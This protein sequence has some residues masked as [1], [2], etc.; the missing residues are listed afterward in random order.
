MSPDPV[1][2]PDPVAPVLAGVFEMLRPLFSR[3]ADRLV[4]LQDAPDR[5]FLG[6]HE[7]RAR[8]GYRTGF[9]GVEIRKSF[10]SV[11]LMPVYV[12]PDLL[13]GLSPEL[14]RRMQGKS[15]FNFRKPDPRLF[16]ELSGL[17]AAGLA[18][19]EADGRLRP[20]P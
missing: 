20:P 18:R 7:V 11:H 19:F 6:T 4:V 13:E 14:R 3:H 1:S 8:D 10:V 15:C 17:V 5:Y 16:E 12:H 9:G 2:P